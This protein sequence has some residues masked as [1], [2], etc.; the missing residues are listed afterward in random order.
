MAEHRYSL[1]R[2]GFWNLCGIRAL[3]KK[4]AF[5]SCVA[6]VWPR[7]ESTEKPA[8]NGAFLSELSEPDPEKSTGSL[9]VWAVAAGR[10]HGACGVLKSLALNPGPAAIA[11]FAIT[12]AMADVLRQILGCIAIL[13]GRVSNSPCRR[14]SVCP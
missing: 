14:S 9:P 12:A 4:M 8:L 3:H 2:H 6:T 7:Q 10:N 5:L 11:G 13:A 1:L